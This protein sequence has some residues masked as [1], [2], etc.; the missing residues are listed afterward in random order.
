[1]PA[2]YNVTNNRN[3][4]IITQL[5]NAKGKGEGSDEVNAL[6]E[7]VKIDTKKPNDEFLNEF[8]ALRIKHPF[9]N[10]IC[11]R[12]GGILNSIGY[13]LK[14]NDYRAERYKAIIN[15]LKTGHKENENTIPYFERG[16]NL[17]KSVCA[18]VE[19]IKNS[20]LEN[21]YAN[22]DCPEY[23]ND[24]EIYDSL[25]RFNDSLGFTPE[26]DNYRVLTTSDHNTLDTWNEFVKVNPEYSF[27]KSGHQADV[28]SSG[29]N[30]N[31]TKIQD[32][33]SKLT[34]QLGLKSGEELFTAEGGLHPTTA[35]KIK[36]QA[37]YEKIF[38]PCIKLS[39]KISDQKY[40][41][42]MCTLS[43]NQLSG[44]INMESINH[45]IPEK[46]ARRMAAEASA[47]SAMHSMTDE[48]KKENETRTPITVNIDVSNMDDNIVQKISYNGEEVASAK[49]MI[50]KQSALTK[51]N[52]K[53]EEYCK[54]RGNK[55]N[56]RDKAQTFM[57]LSHQDKTYIAMLTNGVLNDID[58]PIIRS[59]QAEELA[60][61]AVKG[62]PQIKYTD[63][64]RRELL[65]EV[66]NVYNVHTTADSKDS[67]GTV[68]TKSTV[69]LLFS[70]GKNLGQVKVKPN[71]EYTEMELR[72]PSGDIKNRIFT[73]PSS[74][75]SRL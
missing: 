65:I 55:I 44:Y 46:Q 18:K 45:N 6:A 5:T 74:S 11:Q 27:F 71:I 41:R 4:R 24:R 63:N 52:K 42:K 64:N 13:G 54:E 29:I 26:K 39:M 49:D 21:I 9:I 59:F 60:I 30:I 15:E 37:A 22:A 58:K 31:G 38:V 43:K 25:T 72:T 3:A 51:F 2:V 12:R 69:K 67:V 75:Y 50:C 28:Q 47:L 8:R 7:L 34:E 14:N 48:I 56:H 36:Q 20:Y 19:G 66:K 61:A 70:Q 10:N 17:Q 57:K 35:K 1:M 68:E 32:I 33:K 62:Y 16:T 23:K 40:F 73:H 53:F